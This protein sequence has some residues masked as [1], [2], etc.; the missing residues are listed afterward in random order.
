MKGDEKMKEPW[1]TDQWHISFLNFLP[2]VR[3]NFHF[4]KEVIISDCTLREGEQQ[5]S[6]VLSPSD[7]LRLAREFDEIGIHQLEVGMPAVSEEEFER[8]MDELFRVIAPGDAFILGVG[9]NVVPDAIF[10]RVIRVSE[11]V[12]ERGTYPIK[13]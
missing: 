10:G 12:R 11:L 6:V 9:D 2:E 3:E 4:P 5:A 7:K 1:A 8:H 13:A